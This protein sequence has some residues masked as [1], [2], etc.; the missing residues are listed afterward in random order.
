MP[1]IAG[2]EEAGRGPVIGPMVL[3]IAVI[4]SSKE[5]VLR[6]MGVRDSKQ[7]SPLKRNAIYKRLKSILKVY[8]F[9][10]I[11]P[12]EIDDALFSSVNNL[13]KLEADKTIELVQMVEKTCKIDEIYID[14]PSTN[15]K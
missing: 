10:I 4:E 14:C 9:K 7:L 8:K 1:I 13:N 12:R 3:A 6:E 15:T 5:S 2:I 11:S